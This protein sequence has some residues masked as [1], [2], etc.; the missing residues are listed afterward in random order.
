MFVL[1]HLNKKMEE[2]IYVDEGL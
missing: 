2:S 1:P